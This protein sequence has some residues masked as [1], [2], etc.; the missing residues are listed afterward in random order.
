MEEASQDV[1]KEMHESRVP[2]DDQ[3][4][5]TAEPHTLIACGDFVQVKFISNMKVQLHLA[6]VSTMIKRC[7]HSLATTTLLIAYLFYC[8]RYLK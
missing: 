8:Y 5:R 1:E 4:E 6:K 7:I 3:L 2:E